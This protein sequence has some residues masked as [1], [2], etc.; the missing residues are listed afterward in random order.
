MPNN[1]VMGLA[2]REYLCDGP[3]LA[4]LALPRYVSKKKHWMD[5]DKKISLNGKILVYGGQNWNH[6]GQSNGLCIRGGA[7]PCKRVRNRN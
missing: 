4:Q 3:R 7:E 5:K 1:C 2:A 6:L